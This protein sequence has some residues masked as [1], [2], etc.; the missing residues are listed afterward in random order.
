[1]AVRVQAQ[2]GVNGHNPESRLFTGNLRVIK[3]TVFAPN[4]IEYQFGSKCGTDFE[5]RHYQNFSSKSRQS[6]AGSIQTISRD[7]Y[8]KFGHH[9]KGKKMNL[10]PESR[11]A[12]SAAW[13]GKKR[14][15]ETR[16]K[17][18]A[19]GG[20]HLRGKK[21]SPEHIAKCRDA[22]LGKKFTAEH[23]AKIGAALRGK[24]KS[25][26]ARRKMSIAAKLR[27][28]RQKLTSAQNS[29]SLPL[30]L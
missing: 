21:Q 16:A 26:E 8:A 18:S 29:G 9:N 30:S 27:C 19:S 23:S 12:I 6:E 5:L 28:Q 24:P 7:K 22:K 1:M 20:H 13:K 17:M 2:N 15:A 25:D 14:S 3:S 10:S 4:T 11:A